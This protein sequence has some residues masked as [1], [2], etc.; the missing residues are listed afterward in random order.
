MAQQ[1][2]T[3]EGSRVALRALSCGWVLMLCVGIGLWLSGL[4]SD[5]ALLSA[6]S[7][8]VTRSMLSYGPRKKALRLMAAALLL[9][10]AWVL[11]H[12]LSIF[13]A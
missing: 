5:M 11:A 1:A 8:S 3:T 13:A 4:G 7:L 12:R 2:H 10:A 9:T 6:G